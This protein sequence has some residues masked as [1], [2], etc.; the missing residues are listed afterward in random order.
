VSHLQS[1]FSCTSEVKVNSDA[2]EFSTISDQQLLPPLRQLCPYPIGRI[3]ASGTSTCEAGGNL[4]N[5]SRAGP[6]AT[7]SAADASWNA[8][9]SQQEIAGA[10]GIIK[11]DAELD[12]QTAIRLK[13]ALAE[14]SDPTYSWCS[15]KCW[16]RLG[17]GNLPHRFAQ[18]S[19]CQTS[20]SPH[21]TRETL[22]ALR[23]DPVSPAIGF[24]GSS[25]LTFAGLSKQARFDID[26]DAA[27]SGTVVRRRVG[28]DKWCL[29]ISNEDRRHH[30]Q[31]GTSRTDSADHID[32][33]MAYH[34][35]H[36]REGRSL[37]YPERLRGP[38]L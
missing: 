5:I 13:K 33:K 3:F 12:N 15:N 14:R 2:T 22:S 17:F 7:A 29:D 35:S 27:K 36:R 16:T 19:G 9:A 10:Y 24:L 32:V 21:S 30:D 38:A 18:E 34:L 11:Q 6:V 8:N 28:A 4:T 37:R 20:S 31:A 25:N 26:H 1:S 23:H